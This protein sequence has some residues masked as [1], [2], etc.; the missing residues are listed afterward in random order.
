MYQ[1]N[2]FFIFYYSYSPGPYYPSNDAT[3]VSPSN[4][5]VPSPPK[6]YGDKPMNAAPKYRRKRS[7]ENNQIDEEKFINNAAMF[8]G[9]I[10][11]MSKYK[12]HFLYFR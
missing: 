9:N 2:K 6:N 12:F 8:L 1:T 3:G 5:G 10:I 7:V 4:Y 11:S